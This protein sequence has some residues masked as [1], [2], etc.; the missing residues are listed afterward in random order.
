VWIE[1]SPEIDC[2]Y[3]RLFPGKSHSH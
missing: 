3:C 2:I 1:R